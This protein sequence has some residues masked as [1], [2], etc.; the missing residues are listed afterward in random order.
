M[1]YE[2]L[3][4]LRYL[5][6][7][8]K[9]AH[10]AF[11]SAI[12][13]LGLG[14]GVGTLIISLALLSGLQGNI[15]AR[16][17]AAS[18]QLLIEPSGTNTIADHAAV[19]RQAREAGI[20]SIHPIVSGFAWGSSREGERGRPLLVRSYMPGAEPPA[21]ISFGAEWRLP[22]S[23]AQDSILLTRD[24]AAAMGV[25][26]GDEIVIVAPRTKLTPFGPV[27][28]WRRYRVAR[29]VPAGGDEK[30]PQ[31]LLP[32]DEASRLFATGGGPTS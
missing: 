22:E 20:E 7:A 14:V 3:I 24:F 19:I 11:L 26:F 16:L 1:N 2:S 21:D 12:S 30:A 9:K 5:W 31:A 10:T 28:V 32:Y 15:K 6:A 27:P 25:T 18:P 8:R 17:M 23:D 29:I 4:A 13:T